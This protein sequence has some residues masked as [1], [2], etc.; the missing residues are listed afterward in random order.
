MQAHGFRDLPNPLAAEPS[1]QSQPQ[2]LYQSKENPE[3]KPLPKCR[4]QLEERTVC[5]TAGEWRAF[6]AWKMRNENTL[7]PWPIP[8]LEHTWGVKQ[9]WTPAHPRTGSPGSA[10]HL[11]PPW[12]WQK[13]HFPPRTACFVT[14]G[15][16]GMP[17]DALLSCL[18]LCKHPHP[19]LHTLGAK[20]PPS[21]ADKL[22]GQTGTL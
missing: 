12:A 17:R 19:R 16:A 3:P 7:S 15:R 9:L 4:T 1:A 18:G 14:H 22:L 10:Q 8:D 2:G 5:T 21:S 13:R 20:Q 6:P 11:A